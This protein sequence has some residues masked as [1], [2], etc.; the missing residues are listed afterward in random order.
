MSQWIVTLFERVGAYDCAIVE[1]A[2]EREA[3][4]KGAEDLRDQW[5][6]RAEPGDGPAEVD[7]VFVAPWDG[8]VAYVT[9]PTFEV[10]RA[11]LQCC[12]GPAPSY[13][14]CGGHYATCPNAVRE[15][16]EEDAEQVGE[17]VAG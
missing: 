7:H 1:A 2:D 17:V 6:E 14:H 11:E 10:E 9:V 3:A 16:A 15:E 12:G 5:D 4:V 13:V 8:R